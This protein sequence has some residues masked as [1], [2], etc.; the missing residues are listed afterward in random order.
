MSK[1][2]LTIDF[3]I[4]EENEEDTFELGGTIKKEGAA[5]II[6]SWLRSQMGAGA[7]SS[8]PKQRKTYHLE[9]DWYPSNDRFVCRSDCGNKGLRDGLL[10][11]VLKE[12][13]GGG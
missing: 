10:L 12:L 2:T 5:E 4:G 11:Y 9:I 6:E 7:D 13:N 1:L 3:T 8:E